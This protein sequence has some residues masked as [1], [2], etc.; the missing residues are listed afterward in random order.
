MQ[1]AQDHVVS[2]DYTLKDDSGT[3]VDSSEGREPLA[4]LHGH[5]NIIPGLE[6]ALE[7]RNPG[8]SLTV[9]IP[10]AEAYGERDE[11]LVQE[12]ERSQFP[13]DAAIEPGLMFRAQVGGEM[14][15]FTVE[16]VE[17]DT[18]RING[19]HALAGMDLHF[20]V[21]VR[22]VRKASKTEIEHGHVHHG[23]DHSHH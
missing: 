2:I 18:V 15:V 13:E 20:D 3:V 5:G 8:E 14:R 1:S 4:Y 10:A 23:G 19:N 6:K 21:E 17:G 9:S 22:D 16:S 11:R 12:V 7:G